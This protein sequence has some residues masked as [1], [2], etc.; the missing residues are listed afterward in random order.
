[1]ADKS[2]LLDASQQEMGNL[3]RLDKSASPSSSFIMMQRKD[4]LNNELGQEFFEEGNGA[5]NPEDEIVELQN[6]MMNQSGMINQSGMVYHE[7]H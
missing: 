5:I 3:N 1:M 4:T 7:E 6:S 2:G